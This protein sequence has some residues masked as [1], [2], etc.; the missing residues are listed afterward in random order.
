MSEKLDSI[1]K[2]LRHARTNSFHHG[3]GELTQ[4][5]VAIALNL[6]AEAYGHYERGRSEISLEDVQRV[7]KLTG[8]NLHWLLTGELPMVEGQSEKDIF[9]QH[10]QDAKA[11]TKKTIA[12]MIGYKQGK[13]GK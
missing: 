1:G 3:K 2:R 13:T 8:F 9:W 12:D 6:T 10:Y 5:K 4:G 11:H 7:A